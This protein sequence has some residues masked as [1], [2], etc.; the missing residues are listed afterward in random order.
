MDEINHVSLG[1]ARCRAVLSAKAHQIAPVSILLALMNIAGYHF[2]RQIVGGFVRPGEGFE[3]LAEVF[4]KSG[5]GAHSF[6][7]Y[8]VF[9]TGPILFNDS[10]AELKKTRIIGAHNGCD[11]ANTHGVEM[12]Q[13]ERPVPDFRID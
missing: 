6:P 10:W 8:R 11:D 9:Q 7:Y 3:L 2:I 13:V 5:I 12:P 1:I 4:G